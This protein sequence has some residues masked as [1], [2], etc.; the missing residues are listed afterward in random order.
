MCQSLHRFTRTFHLLPEA[1][2]E[3]E[4][5]CVVRDRELAGVSSG[6][7]EKADLVLCVERDAVSESWE[8]SVAEDL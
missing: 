6:P 2:G 5:V 8:R 3:I 7:T 1:G 4:S